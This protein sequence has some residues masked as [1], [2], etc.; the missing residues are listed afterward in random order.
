[1]TKSTNS[2]TPETESQAFERATDLG[3]AWTGITANISRE[4]VEA[5]RAGFMAARGELVNSH[6]SREALV[7]E[8]KE[9]LQAAERD[10]G[11]TYDAI[12]QH[13]GPVVSIGQFSRLSRTRA[14]LA[15]MEGR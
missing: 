9:A 7:G 8:L 10:L 1:M 4:P 13:G 2:P 11:A 5:F 12:M 6:A 14:L 3:V 15:K